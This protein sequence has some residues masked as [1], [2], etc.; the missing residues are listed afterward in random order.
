M[1]LEHEVRN[2]REFGE[3]GSAYQ[4][5]AAHMLRL[6]RRALLPL[7]EE[8]EADIPEDPGNA[9]AQLVAKR[10]RDVL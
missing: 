2:V 1:G 8:L 6:L 7:I 9:T 5:G 4:A 3:R 10:L